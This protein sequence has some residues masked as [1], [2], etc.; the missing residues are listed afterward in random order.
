[1]NKYIL[2]SF[3]FVSLLVFSQSSPGG[4]SSD[5]TL[6]L[7][8]D[9]GTDSTVDNDPILSWEDQGPGGFD[10]TGTG[11]ATYLNDVFNYNPVIEFNGGAKPFESASITRP[12]GTASTVFLVAKNS[13][14]PVHH[15]NTKWYSPKHFLKWSNF[16]TPLNLLF[17][18][19]NNLLA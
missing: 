8:A 18:F 19:A 6:W 9:A 5:L 4:V 7:K 12:N 1:M 10:A 2:T 3:L 11:N 17:S 14:S 13:A 16:A 15:H